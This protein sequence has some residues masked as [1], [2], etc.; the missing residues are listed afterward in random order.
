[1][2]RTSYVT[3]ICQV[4]TGGSSTPTTTTSTMT[5]VKFPPNGEPND[6]HADGLRLHL[7]YRAQ[8]AAL[9]HGRPPD[10][11]APRCPQVVGRAHRE[12]DRH[13]PGLR[14]V[15]HREAQDPAM[16]ASGTQEVTGRGK[17]PHG[18]LQVF[19]GS[20]LMGAFCT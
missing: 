1:M 16:G 10:Q 17:S 2:M 11:S 9:Q 15:Q 7:Q 13:Q 19:V 3:L 20:S 8:V 18:T 12:L 14:T 6:R 4:V 5:A